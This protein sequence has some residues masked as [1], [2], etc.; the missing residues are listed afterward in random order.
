MENLLVFPVRYMLGCHA[1]TLYPTFFVCKG[2]KKWNGFHGSQTSWCD[3]TIFKKQNLKT[4]GTQD[5]KRKLL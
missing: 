5:V 3:V 1:Q 4:A 2:C